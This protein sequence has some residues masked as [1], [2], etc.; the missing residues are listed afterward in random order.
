M[1]RYSGKLTPDIV[2]EPGLSHFTLS[3][4]KLLFVLALL[5]LPGLARASVS[6]ERS[7]AG[8][9]ITSPVVVSI[10]ADTIEELCPSYPDTPFW[11]IWAVGI[12]GSDDYFSVEENSSDT[13]SGDFTLNLP[14][15][16]YSWLLIACLYEEVNWGTGLTLEFSYDPGIF[17]IVEPTIGGNILTIPSTFATGMLAYAGRLF[18]DLQV[19][20]LLIIGL[21]VGFYVIEQAVEK[22]QDWFDDSDVKEEWF[23]D[24]RAHG[25]EDVEEAYERG[26]KDD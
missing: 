17:E 19:W 8:Y 12:G 4:K 5:L 13:L 11:K 1:S 23:E 2:K 16:A 3:M 14:T 6:Y 7:P 10:S 18:L 20:I 24:A 9:S 25:L 26:K 15:G 22:G 21:P